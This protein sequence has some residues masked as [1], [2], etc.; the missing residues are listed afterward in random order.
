MAS[1]DILLRSR[2][3]EIFDVRNACERTLRITANR[4]SANERI[5]VASKQ[6]MSS[7]NCKP[8]TRGG[9]GSCT[10]LVEHTQVRQAGTWARTVTSQCSEWPNHLRRHVESPSSLNAYRDTHSGNIILF[11]CSH[12]ILHCID[13]LLAHIPCNAMYSD[14][15]VY[16]RKFPVSGSIV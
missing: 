5:L 13:S 16:N 14:D 7:T 1:N 15:R 12:Y 10:A 2:G 8:T 4:D 3:I 9:S 11:S 6:R